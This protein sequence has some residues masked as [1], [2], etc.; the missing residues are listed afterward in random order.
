MSPSASRSVPVFPLPGV[1]LF[2]HA[3]LP[4][5]V[6]ELRYRTMVR[7]A[8]SGGRVLA[9]ATLCDGWEVDYHDSP[10]FHPIGCLARFEQ[11]EWLPNDCYDLVLEGVE[12][13]RFG[14]MT[15]EFPYRACEYEALPMAP[16]EADDPLADMERQALL[17]A[18]QALL[19][20]GAQAWLAP[21]VTAADASFEGVVNTLA[22]CLRLPVA[23]RLELLAM[24]SV[25][26]RAR[27][28]QEHMARIRFQP[29]SD[30]GGSPQVN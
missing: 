5:H 7:D 4:L 26:E 22:Q 18:A 30:E 25:F 6:F 19:P 9:L 13:V 20:R 24:D 14:R 16:Y 12:R 17:D 21:P 3:R 11:I 29:L 10:P 28:L 2:P 27:R 1:V 8:L 15:R 23:S